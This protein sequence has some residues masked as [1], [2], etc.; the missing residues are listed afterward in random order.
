MDIVITEHP[1][2]MVGVRPSPGEA[3]GGPHAA[4]WNHTM[5]HTSTHPFIQAH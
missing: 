4:L 3:G 2:D 5:T 1:E